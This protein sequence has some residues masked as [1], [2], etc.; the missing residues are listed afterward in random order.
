MKK[1]DPILENKSHMGF[2]PLI[3]IIS[4]VSSAR[5][6]SGN[7]FIMSGPGFIFYDLRSHSP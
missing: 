4:E 6:R 7:Y 2:F 1:R 5:P 3:G